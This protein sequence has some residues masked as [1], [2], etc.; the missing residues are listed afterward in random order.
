M[1]T[2]TLQPEATEQTKRLA[3]LYGAKRFA[4]EAIVV[5]PCVSDD[6]QVVAVYE[7]AERKT[8]DWCPEGWDVFGR[9]VTVHVAEDGTITEVER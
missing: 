6:G 9:C 3:A 7:V 8:T 1:K 2:L 5:N 4:T